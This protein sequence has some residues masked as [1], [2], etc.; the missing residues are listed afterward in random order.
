MVKLIAYSM[1]VNGET[2]EDILTHAF[3][4]CYQTKPNI[5]AVIRNLK[6]QSVLE[7]ITFTFDIQLSRVAWEQLVRHRVA[8]YTAQSHRYTDIKEEDFHFYIP[9]EIRREDIDE[10]IADLK[11]TYL[12]YK[13]WRDRGYKK[14][15]ARYQAS[16]GV[17]IKATVSFNLRSL[18][19]LLSLRTDAH[20][21]EEIRK[22]AEEVWLSVKHLF[23]RL[24]N[25]LEGSFR[26]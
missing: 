5:Q 22:F 18:L 16:K 13:K 25:T 20:A 1:G 23:P 12:I 9:D 10:W 3:S 21:Q 2:P 14:E 7:H 8:S 15:T 6:H 19:N 24:E 17:S 26:K 11:A 4:Q